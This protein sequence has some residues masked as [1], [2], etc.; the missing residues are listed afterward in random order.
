MSVPLTD[1]VALM[2]QELDI[3]SFDDDSQ[4]GLQVEGPSTVAR[5]GLA[6]DA[7]LAS[8]AA[9]VA[10]NCQLL[11]VHHGMFW[12]KG[13]GPL[14]GANYR[15]VAT[16]LEN[17]LALY[18][19]HLPLDA[20]PTLGN[21][22]RIASILGVADAHPFALYHGRD[23]GIA[24]SLPEPAGASALAA[25]LG[26][27]ITD[28]VGVTCTTGVVG[29]PDRSIKTL[30]IV[31]GGGTLAIRECVAAGLDALV[32][33]EGP[34]QANIDAIDNGLTLVYAGHYE[35]ETLGVNALGGLLEQ[36]FDLETVFLDVPH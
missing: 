34:H 2:D 31:S 9:A 36:K 6:V 26:K 20:H 33:G 25:R 12:S 18:A 5:I 29:P 10:A 27:A 35:T 22:A 14:T 16:L 8:F 32:S 11:V 24:G 15:R 19:C 4:N 3:A 7:C 17:K 30:G 28:A 21:N 1:L 23:I 13:L